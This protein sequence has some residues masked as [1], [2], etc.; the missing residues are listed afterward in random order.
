MLELCNMSIIATIRESDLHEIDNPKDDSQYNT[1]TAAR[2]VL[3]DDDNKVHLIF[4][5][6]DGYHK[7]PGGGVEPGE[8]I[9]V[10]LKR[11]LLEEV[12]CQ[13]NIIAEIGTIIEYRGY[14]N[15]K[16]TSICYLARQHGV[17]QPT[18][19]EDYEL[20]AGM[21]DI[22]VNSIDEAIA[23]LEKDTPKNTGEKFMNKRD[24]AFLRSA[25]SMI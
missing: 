4:V 22:T 8:G 19:L 1:R 13:A 15:L 23:K 3:L 7:L 20:A 6:A 9:E 21:I 18:S 2:A 17:K 12:G 14:N 10:A 16:Q 24:L 5:G 11:E 25:K